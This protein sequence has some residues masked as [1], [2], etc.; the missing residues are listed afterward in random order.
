M[1][2]FDTISVHFDTKKDSNFKF[3]GFELV[4]DQDGNGVY[5]EAVDTILSSVP[6]NENEKRG[7]VYFQLNRNAKKYAGKSLNYFL[8]RAKVD[9]IDPNLKPG[10]TTKIAANTAFHFFLEDNDVRVNGEIEGSKATVSN[11]KFESNEKLEFA[12]FYLEPTGD[13]FIITTGIHDPAVPAVSEINNNI[14]V[15]QIRTKSIGKKNSIKQLKIKVPSNKYVKF[16]DKNGITGISLWLDP[17]NDGQ[18]DVKIAEKTSFDASES[19]SVTFDSS[20]FSQSLKY[21]DGEEKYFVV[22]VDFNM[23]DA[24]PAMVGRIQIP[25]GGIKLEKDANPYELP[26]NSKAYTYACADGDTNCETDKKSGGCAVLEVE[27][28]NTNMIVIAA[29]LSAAAM[30]GFALLRKKLF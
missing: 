29:V 24:D 5:D 7:Y 13:Y 11:E 2:N 21:G 25:K 30:L 4:Y 12:T 10:E 6:E 23:V 26:L 27:S 9:Y 16:G 8:V 19:T 17:N 14:P 18:G 22:Y 1:F 15:M 20:T 3:S 28:D